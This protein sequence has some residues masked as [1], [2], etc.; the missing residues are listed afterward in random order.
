MS[1]LEI[2]EAH[3]GRHFD[4]DGMRV[5]Q[6]GHYIGH[7]NGVEKRHRAHVA[8]LL[9]AHMREREAEALEEAAD[10]LDKKSSRLDR[11]F[12]TEN[13]AY[14]GLNTATTELRNRAEKIKEKP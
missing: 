4:D 9:E 13:G 8:E 2:L 10:A 11:D 5:C 12:A 14:L 6:C 7:G 3:T 1:V